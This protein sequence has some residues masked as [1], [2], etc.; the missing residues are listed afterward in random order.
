MLTRAGRGGPPRLLFVVTEDWYF[1]SHRLPLAMAARRDGFKVAVATRIARHRLEIDQA[2]I[3][4]IPLQHLLRSSVNPW[5]E[6]LAVSELVRIYRRWRPDIVHH[7]ALKPVLYGS[8]AAR[9]AAVRGCVNALPGLGYVFSA[10]GAKAGAARFLVRGTLAWVARA[11]TWHNIVQN[12]DDE[13]LLRK[14]GASR[15]RTHLIRGAGV[16]VERFQCE[17]PPDGNVVLMAGRMLWSKGVGDFVEV[18]RL[19]RERGIDARFLLLGEPDEANPDCVPR[20]RLEE[21]KRSGVVE[22]GGYRPDIEVALCRAAVVCLPTTYGEGVPKILL[23]AASCGRPIVA[24]DVPGCREIVRD[25]VNGLLVPPGDVKGLMSAVLE[26]LED[27]ARRT[28]MGAMGRQI[29]LR[30]FSQELVHRD[31]LEVY[32]SLVEG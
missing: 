25:G 14:L 4:A 12:K 1:V 11:R 5:R 29:V 21:W 31:T 23:E 18:A 32:R 26:L 8:I 15:S 7:V 17:G 30:E 22:W 3:E 2:G 16:D 19:V 9:L 6:T 10:K 13:A 28:T 24:Y 27:G 20:E